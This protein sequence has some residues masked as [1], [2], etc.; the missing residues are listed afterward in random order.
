MPSDERVGAVGDAEEVGRSWWMRCGNQI[1][2]YS[3]V[4]ESATAGASYVRTLG[5][6]RRFW[7]RIGFGYHAA[8]VPFMI[9]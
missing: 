3:S 7:R 2:R 6:G 9:S 1:L 4:L 5:Y 8:H